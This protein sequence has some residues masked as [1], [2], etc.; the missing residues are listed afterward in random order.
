MC[1][2]LQARTRTLNFLRGIETR[3]GGGGGGG[4]P[5]NRHCSRQMYLAFFLSSAKAA[6]APAS[7]LALE[8]YEGAKVSGLVASYTKSQPFFHGT[9][10][11]PSGRF[12]SDRWRPDG[13]RWDRVL[14]KVNV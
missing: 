5:Q 2:Q 7:L 13:S 12:P 10:V 9:M 14:A 1:I 11:T 4:P 8:V 3:G 6:T